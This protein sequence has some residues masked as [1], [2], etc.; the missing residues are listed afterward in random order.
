MSYDFMSNQFNV[1]MLI[2]KCL[3]LSL[4]GNTDFILSI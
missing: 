4:E 2:N 1:K 3:T